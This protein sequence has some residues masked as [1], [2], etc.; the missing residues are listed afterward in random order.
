VC[1]TFQDLAAPVIYSA[2]KEEYLSLIQSADSNI[3]G[4]L[5]RERALFHLNHAEIGRIL[6]QKLELPEVFVDA[7]A[8]HHN[9]DRLRELVESEVIADAVHSAS[10][11]PHFINT[12]HGDDVEALLAFLTEHSPVDKADGFVQDVQNDFA[13]LY[14]FFQDGG[15][16]DTQLTEL[17]EQITRE[18]ADNTTKLVSTVNE[19]MQQAA[20]TGAQMNRFLK[21]GEDPEDKSM[22]D[23]LTGVLNREGFVEKAEELLAKAT[24]YGIGFGVAYL[25]LDEFNENNA[26]HGAEVKEAALTAIA[27]ELRQTTT[28]KGL[29]G[30]LGNDKFVVFL[31]ECNETDATELL[32]AA[33]SRIAARSMTRGKNS[34]QTTI[35]AGIVYVRPTNRQYK[36]DVLLRAAEKFMHEAR[37]D[38]GDQIKLRVIKM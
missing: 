16:P 8:F 26:R 2:A 37:G 23:P 4:Q 30:R 18:A 22:R 14:G 28:E 35:S 17:V 7:V 19:F 13:H 36:L 6:A 12:W 34:V 5:E 24:R 1:G 3:A 29:V 38:G 10:L 31:N 21:G 20:S 33:R 27:N 9:R 11:F 32:E 25:G 15:T